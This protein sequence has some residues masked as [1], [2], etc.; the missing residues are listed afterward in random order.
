MGKGIKEYEYMREISEEHSI[1]CYT[2][3]ICTLLKNLGYEI[4]EYELWTL[5]NGFDFLEGYDEYG[6]PEILFDVFS[7]VKRFLKV[8][9]CELIRERIDFDNLKEEL[10]K[11]L[12]IQNNLVWV[13]SKHMA[14]S[15]LYYSNK[16]YVHA[17]VLKSFCKEKNLIQV[18]DDLIV[19]MPPWSC[20]ADLHYDY[21]YKALHDTVITESPLYI[22]IMGY[23]YTI[24]VKEDPIVINQDMIRKYLHKMTIKMVEDIKNN[25]S[26]IIKYSEN[27]LRY[28][29]SADDEK[30]QWMLRRMNDNIKTLYV[31]PNREM[32]KN[33]LSHIELEESTYLQLVEKLDTVI[34]EWITLANLCLK[35]SVSKN[36]KELSNTLPSS[37]EKVKCTEDIFWN[38]LYQIMEE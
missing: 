6:A 3:G 19:S 11:R 37:F 36:M 13:N 31:L 25:N 27:C 10:T 38:F 29:K 18:R 26:P 8:Y 12:E 35:C 7:I 30:I 5:G 24:K 4:K 28:M 21:L 23:F 2:G 16:G 20:T 1:N 33:V 17:I 34:K 9:N 32:L 14:Y 22:D 15:D